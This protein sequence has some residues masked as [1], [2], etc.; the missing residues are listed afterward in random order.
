MQKRLKKTDSVTTDDFYFEPVGEDKKSPP[1]GWRIE[2]NALPDG[3]DRWRIKLSGA[4]CDTFYSSGDLKS[5]LGVGTDGFLYGDE[6]EAREYA[7]KML[8]DAYAAV[9]RKD[10][11]FTVTWDDIST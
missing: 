4:Y 5:W 3:V 1:L 8:K 9:E 6:K 11:K 2:A 10:L 7:C